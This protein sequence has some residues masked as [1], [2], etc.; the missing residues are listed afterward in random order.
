M[1]SWQCVYLHGIVDYTI[2]KGSSLWSNNYLY[3]I[4]LTKIGSAE[5]CS[6]ALHAVLYP[7]NNGNFQGPLL[8]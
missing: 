8:V 3:S 1:Y 4:M 7:S 2:G 6:Y 5:M